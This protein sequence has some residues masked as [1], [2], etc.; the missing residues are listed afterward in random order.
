M[1]FLNWW[2]NHSGRWDVAA[3]TLFTLVS[4]VL[5]SVASTREPGS[6]GLY[7][8][9]YARSLAFD[10]DLDFTNDYAQCGDPFGIGIATPAHRPA[11]FFY[12]GP[13]VFWTPAIWVLKHFVRDRP[14]VACNGVIPHDVL[15]M[16]SFAG[17]VVVL[18]TSALV[19]RFV[20]ARVA[21]LATLIVAFGGH[22]IFF[23]AMNAAYSHVYDAMCVAVFLWAIVRVREEPTRS[24][25]WIVAGTFLGLAIL[26]RSIGVVF[27]GV[28]ATALVRQNVRAL[29]VIG[30]LAFVTGVV[31]LLAANHA[32]YGLWTVYTHGP[33]FIRY[34]HAHPIL[35]VFDQRGGVFAWAP[36]LWLVVP[37]VVVLARRRDARW[38]FVPLA[39]C[40]A[41]ELYVSSAALD[42]EG[43]RRLMNLTPLGALAI[44]AL[45]EPV[46]RW[47]VA[48]RL[49]MAYALGGVAIAALAWASA[50]V[51][52]GY[53]AGRIPW[54]QPVGMGGRFGEGQAAALDATESALGPLGSLP[55][56][57]VFS[58]R[59][60]LSPNA[61]GWGVHAD[62][63]ERHPQTLEYL[64]NGFAFTSD[65]GR[66]L[67]RGLAVDR[68]HSDRGA[69]FQRRHAS[70]VLSIQWPVATRARISYAAKETT[71]LAVDSRTFF[72]ARTSWGKVVLDGGGP[73][74]A[75]FTLPP[76][77]LDSGVNE[78]ELDAAADG[79]CLFA[80]EWADDTRYPASPESL[81]SFPVM[82]WHASAP[83]G[84]RAEILAKHGVSIAN[85]RFHD[86]VVDVVQSGSKLRMRAGTIDARGEIAWRLVRDYDDGKDP[87][88]AIDPNTGHGVEMHDG[89]DGVWTHEVDVLP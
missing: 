83:R 43:A 16:S 26:Q 45:T 61:F 18:A 87:Q 30:A 46:A 73:G 41:F 44:G 4:L 40:G 50:G 31:P 35:F 86:N 67:S 57:W 75:Y 10:H 29:L 52:V 2:K 33:H 36:A 56:A 76:A 69:C 9:L 7:S 28:A 65:A 64:S 68:E 79:V 20:E 81:E 11:N 24:R 6:D 34:A 49:R 19:R 12:I 47:L 60:G 13:A 70:V 22:L 39:L 25:W 38:L 88:I 62:W 89:D 3:A 63:Y 1:R 27:F 71:T 77:A 78:I 66:M 23:S 84:T 85:H 32:I 21:A 42:W 51:S 82:I 15:M 17:G 74:E 55:A 53:H 72:G 80:I 5:Y 37:G 54:D 14:N 58:A 48:A 59:Y 8:W